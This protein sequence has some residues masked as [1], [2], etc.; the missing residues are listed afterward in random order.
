M[1]IDHRNELSQPFDI[2]L[3]EFGRRS[4]YVY[5][6]VDL[7]LL[8]SHKRDFRGR[9]DFSRYYLS[10]RP[11]RKILQMKVN[12]NETCLALI[13][14]RLVYLVDLSRLCNDGDDQSRRICLPIKSCDKSTFDSKVVE[15]LWLND[16]SFVILFSDRPCDLALFRCEAVNNDDK[17]IRCLGRVRFGAKKQNR[18]RGKYSLEPNSKIE[19]VLVDRV[20]FESTSFSRLLVETSDGDFYLFDCQDQDNVEFER[21]IDI[22]ISFLPS[23]FDNFGSSIIDRRMNFFSFDSNSMLILF[24]GRS[25]VD[26]AIVLHQGEKKSAVGYILQS[27]QIDSDQRS[28]ELIHFDS[29]FEHGFFLLD[30]DGLVQF[31]ELFSF[32]Q[33]DRTDS[34]RIEQIFVNNRPN[35]KIERIDSIEIEQDRWTSP[36]L[37]L[38]FSSKK[39]ILL[40]CPNIRPRRTINEPTKFDESVNLLRSIPAMNFDPKRIYTAAE[41]SRLLE[42]IEQRFIVDLFIKE[43][44]IKDKVEQSNRST[45]NLFVQQKRRDEFNA[46]R[47]RR[48]EKAFVDLKCRLKQVVPHSCELLCP[49]ESCSLLL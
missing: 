13:S 47:F 21:E 25:T 32:D 40:D 10:S 46:D 6:Q 3:I 29:N 1:E 30:S 34:T 33:A 48:L 18:P 11:S 22:P 44:R 20:Q 35:T 2:E 24:D 41:I 28:I 27:I 4:I 37:V 43:T 5:D 15:F 45:E 19:R 26:Q 39:F 38:F 42:S 31:V 49:I 8:I 16:D 36:K 9:F 12:R 17:N 14:D 23:R 7:S